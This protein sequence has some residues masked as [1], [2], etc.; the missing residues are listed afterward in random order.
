M[1]ILVVYGGD[2]IFGSL[3]QRL[4]AKLSICNHVVVACENSTSSISGVFWSRIKKAGIFR[5]TSQF[6]FKVY[7]FLFLRSSI[8][9]YAKK[10]LPSSWKPVSINSL[11]SYTAHDFLK[12]HEFD[13]VVAIATSI[14]GSVTLSLPRIGIINLHPGVL[15]N[16]RGTGNFWAVY[17][18]DARCVGCTAH[19]MTSEIDKGLIIDIQTLKGSFNGLWDMNYR[20]FQAGIDK[21]SDIINSGA[22][23]STTVFA[24]SRL[25]RYYSWNGLI[26]YLKFKRNL[27]RTFQ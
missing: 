20:A 15:P 17:N 24:D 1:K 21:L 13:L 7:D 14:L 9:A 5:G 18:N 27:A 11:N 26:Q 25:D 23:F 2:E 19:W 16:Y 10:S 8:R 3:A 4:A 12:E 22:L 6:L